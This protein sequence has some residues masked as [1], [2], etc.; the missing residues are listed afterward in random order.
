MER[1]VSR[2]SDEPRRIRS[3]SR[4]RAGGHLGGKPRAPNR[5]H[6]ETTPSR[7]VAKRRELAK[8]PHINC[9]GIACQSQ[10]RKNTRL[11]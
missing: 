9:L 1:K 3:N 5:L 6:R 8:L 10:I 4:T 2:H 11:R 7:N